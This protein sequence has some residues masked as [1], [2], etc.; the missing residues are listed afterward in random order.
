[1]NGPKVSNC[2]PSKHK[3]VSLKEDKESRAHNRAP[4]LGL[5][6]QTPIWRVEGG[7]TDKLADK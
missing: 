1:M 2:S 4:D 3:C 5:D 7:A 6:N